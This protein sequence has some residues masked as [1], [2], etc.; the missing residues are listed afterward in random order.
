MRDAQS[1]P[2]ISRFS[3]F[4]FAGIAF[5]VSTKRSTASPE[6]AKYRCRECETFWSDLRLAAREGRGS[7]V[8]LVQPRQQHYVPCARAEPGQSASAQGSKQAALWHVGLF[9]VIRDLR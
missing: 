1:N 7:T 8:F 9:C 3:R 5:A 4:V 6:S 2:V